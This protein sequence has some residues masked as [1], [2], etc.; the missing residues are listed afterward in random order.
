MSYSIVTIESNSLKVWNPLSLLFR[1]LRTRA[2]E[3]YIKVGS[4]GDPNLLYRYLVLLTRARIKGLIDPTRY[5]EQ[6][7]RGNT[8][9]VGPKAFIQWWVYMGIGVS[10]FT[11]GLGARLLRLLKLLKG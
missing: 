3:V 7:T 8:L 2:D 10:V 11:L 4:A 9:L 5:V 6:C 1:L